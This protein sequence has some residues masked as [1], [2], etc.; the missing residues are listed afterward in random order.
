MT[1]PEQPGGRTRLPWEKVPAWLRAEAERR[2]GGRVVEAISQ[3]GGFSPGAAARLRLDNGGRVFAKAVGPELNP[4]TPGMF[5]DEARTAAAMPASVPAPRLL[6][7]I[8]AAAEPDAVASGS[9]GW[10][11]LM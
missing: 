7:W 11:L 10:V 8:D 1:S 4:D 9:D 6:G 5:R 3:A 2:L